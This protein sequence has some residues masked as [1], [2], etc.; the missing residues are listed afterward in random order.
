MLPDNII[1]IIILATKGVDLVG[2]NQ[3]QCET[4]SMDT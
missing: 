3:C 1:I 4:A 2:V